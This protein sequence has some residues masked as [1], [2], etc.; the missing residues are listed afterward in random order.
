[1]KINVYRGDLLRLKGQALALF[2]TTNFSWRS[3]PFSSLNKLS[4]DWLRQVVEDSDFKGRAD[5]IHVVPTLNVMPFSK[6]IFVGLGDKPLDSPERLRR[7]SGSLLKKAKAIK[8]LLLNVVCPWPLFPKEKAQSVSAALSE[9][10]LLAHYEF[11]K[12]KA[13]T[14]IADVEEIKICDDTG[15]ANQAQEG[16]NWA[17]T[18][19]DA[20]NYARNLVNEPASSLKPSAL[21]QEAQKISLDDKLVE[22]EVFTG[23]DL[24]ELGAHALIAVSRGSDEPAQFIHLSYKPRGAQKLNTKLCLIGKGI[25]FDSGGLSLKTAEG[26]E[27]MKGDMAG[28]ACILG[29]FKAIS[30]FKPRIEVH[31]LI[32][33]CE[34]MPSGKAL[35]PGD[36]IKTFSGKTVEVLNTDAEGRLVL[37]DALGYAVKKLEADYIID[38]AT[39]TGACVVALGENVAGLMTNNERLE[40]KIEDASEA[41]GEPVWQLPLIEDYKELLKSN[42]A[43]IKN[44]TQKRWAGAITAAL[45][46]REFVEKT[47]WAHLDIA[48]PSWD[49]SGR[50]SYIPKGGTGFGVRTILNLLSNW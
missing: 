45:F 41:E 24:T 4:S 13:Q 17:V 10:F 12:Y 31:G 42:V 38:L 22:T 28:A 20:V 32:P 46:L 50:I 2:V 8:L 39:L 19:C 35:R 6:I 30:K 47:P 37:A 44:V 34:N 27:S 26:M 16:I 49:E 40:D 11:N 14:E 3:E 1:M 25:T 36:V 5:E 33:A 7:A 43:D 48:G 23:R 9:G 18:A 15:R 21:A 29:V